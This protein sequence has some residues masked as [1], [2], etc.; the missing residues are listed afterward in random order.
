[1]LTD[2]ENVTAKKATNHHTKVRN[3]SE[4]MQVQFDVSALILWPG[5][6]YTCIIKGHD[7]PRQWPFSTRD[8][9]HYNIL[10]MLPCITRW[11]WLRKSSDYKPHLKGLWRGC[12]SVHICNSRGS[13]TVTHTTHNSKF[14]FEIAASQLLPPTPTTILA[15]LCDIRNCK[16]HL[17]VVCFETV[18]EHV[19]RPSRHTLASSGIGTSPPLNC[20]C[21]SF[22]SVIKISSK[23]QRYAKMHKNEATHGGHDQAH[24]QGDTPA[25]FANWL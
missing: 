2:G 10:C 18:R 21:N 17:C 7:V 3:S 9:L 13:N 23:S 16:G 25:H 24:R 1:M 8:M 19:G 22:T 15:R 14:Q 6:T 5:T 11:I 20:A 12:P 4:W